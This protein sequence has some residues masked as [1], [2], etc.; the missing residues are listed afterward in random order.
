MPSKTILREKINESISSVLPIA[1]IV[2][3][4]CLSFVPVTTDLMLAFLL[5]TIMLIVGMGLFTL[6]A[7]A[8]MTQI[9]NHIGA[10]MTKSRR[11]WLILVLSFVLGIAITVAEP[12]LQVLASNVPHINTTVLIITVSVGV[13]LFL[14]ICMLRILLGIQLR[15][16]LL[17]CYVIVFALAAFSDAGFLSVAFDSGGV[18]TGPMTVPFIMALGVGV[19]SIRS[20][21]NAEADSFGLVALCSIGP[22]LAVMIL[23]FFYEM[24]DGTVA[25]SVIQSYADTVALGGGYVKAIP[26]YMYEVATAL[27]PIVVFFLLFQVFSLKLRKL[28]FLKIV[29]GLVYTYVGLVLFLVGVNVGF[30]SLGTVLG[31]SLADKAAWLLV[32][33]AMLMGWFIISAEPAVH[34][35][36]KQVEEI[37]A[38]AVSEKA[39]GLSL[40]IA[41]ALATGLA[42]VRV[43]TGIS[44][45]WF[46]VPGYVIALAMSFFVPPIFTAIAFDSGGVASGPMTATFMLPFAMGACE[47]VGGNVITDAFGLVS[48][49]AVMPL[50]TVQVMGAVYL[51]RSKRTQEVF[52]VT[53]LADDEIIELWEV[54]S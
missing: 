6:G 46:V 49:V 20:D 48:L 14:V 18:T 16:V 23:G 39:M 19:A 30:S 22:I 25:A 50:I 34:V 43:L 32:P 54:A 53:Q 37:S 5:G 26:H 2:A 38:G 12:D 33:V 1:V 41:I 27:A 36:N 52:D 11:L 17:G 24:E 3:L 10:K 13:G 4:M 51:V 40:S 44:I 31:A 15:W 29:I 28:P 8:S 35:L 42:M 47:A 21:K 45:L 9:G 7:E